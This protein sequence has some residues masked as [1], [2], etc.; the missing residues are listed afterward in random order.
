MLCVFLL[1]GL[2]FN[3][4][5]VL[6]IAAQKDRRISIDGNVELQMVL[7]PERPDAG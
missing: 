6:D 5:R 2:V 7:H 3:G 4:L 1:T